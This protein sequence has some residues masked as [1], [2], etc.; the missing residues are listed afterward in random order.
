MPKT[1]ELSSI[2]PSAH[3]PALFFIHDGTSCD[4]VGSAVSVGGIIIIPSLIRY[5]IPCR[6]DVSSIWSV[7]HHP[8]LFLTHDGISSC[9]NALGIDKTPTKEAARI[10]K[11]T[12][13][14]YHDFLCF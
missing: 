6:N 2:C 3:Q 8:A 4:P 9:A 14:I 12:N 13:R 5:W 1:N 11:S 7:A 10:K